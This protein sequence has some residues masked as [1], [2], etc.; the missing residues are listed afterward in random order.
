[1][2]TAIQKWGNSQGIRLPKYILDAVQWQDN[3][4]IT[5]K[6]EGDKIIIEKAEKI[7]QKNIKELFADFEGQYVPTEIN[8]G[9][10]I[11]KEIW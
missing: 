5:I 2:T 8:W 11:G 3:E 4:E 10:P 7:E 1:M 9:S 6:A